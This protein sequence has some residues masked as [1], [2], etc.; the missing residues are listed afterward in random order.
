MIILDGKKVKTEILENL[1]LEVQKLTNIPSFAII[2]VGD[3]DASNI[4]IRQKIKMAEYIGYQY[5]YLKFPEDVKEQVLLSKINELNNDISVHGIL[6]QMPLPSHLDSSIIQNA[7]L[8][9]KDIDG[10]SDINT[11]KL[12]H[13]KDT[14][15]SCTPAGI[16]ELLKYYQIEIT[17]KHIVIIG[18]SNLVGKPM[19]AMFTNAGGT[20]TICHSKTNNLEKYTKSA[21]ILIVAVGKPKLITA[22]MVSDNVI[23]IDV[24]INKVDNKLYGDVDYDSV[25]KKASYITPVPGTI[26][27]LAKNILKSYYLQED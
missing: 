17:G 14:L 4:Y 23:V 15:L 26:A 19:A 7:I 18:R 9:Q 25:S 3:N 21:D 10:L 8:P 2:Q 27:I 16:I 24:G 22:D 11:G 6:V 20:V 12:F 13:G 5:H 1:K